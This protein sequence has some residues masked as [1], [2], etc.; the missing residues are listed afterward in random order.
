MEAIE[1]S[2]A[3][4]VE[5]IRW[6]SN[7]NYLLELKKAGVSIPLTRVLKSSNTRREAEELVKEA[8]GLGK[9]VVKPMV[10]ADG[11]GTF[12]I[13][14]QEDLDRAL[15]LC[16]G[17]ELLVQVLSNAIVIVTSFKIKFDRSFFLRF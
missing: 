14:T 3:N 4:P 6:N 16:K 5:V 13:E 8:G 9:V 7:K 1:A 17:Q 10:G 2:L 11:K 15:K 12:I